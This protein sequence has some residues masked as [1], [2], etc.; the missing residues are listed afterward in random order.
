MA[1]VSAGSTPGTTPEKTPG[2]T[3]VSTPGTTPAKTVSAATSASA[4]TE[5]EADKDI[6]AT[7]K[8]QASVR[9]FL[10]RKSQTGQQIRQQLHDRKEKHKSDAGIS[11]SPFLPSAEDAVAE[12][13]KL[14]KLGPTDVVLDVGS[15]D[16]RV[17]VKVCQSHPQ[18]KGIG[19]E[20]LPDLCAKAR[21]A[22]DTAGISGRV[23]IHQVDFLTQ[24]VSSQIKDATVVYLY[25][26]PD[27]MLHVGRLLAQHL[28]VGAR[29]ITY[30]FKLP[31]WGDEKAASMVGVA[32]S[33]L[34]VYT[35]TPTT[36]TTVLA[37]ANSASASSAVSSV[38]SAS[39]SSPSPSAPTST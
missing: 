24:D 22:C 33:P 7:T 39:P 27:A 32:Q 34:Y 15:G 31:G 11:D 13:V 35:V 23:A 25:L 1:N 5:K 29:I 17:L 38:S 18:A 9:G 10:F 16:G 14:A 20:K 21:T 12:F 6:D 28:R 26:L 2:S 3:P 30:T 4:T 36:S 19:L 37:K 8:I